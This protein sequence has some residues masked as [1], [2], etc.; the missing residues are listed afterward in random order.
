MPSFLFHF[1]AS[2]SPFVLSP[3]LFLSHSHHSPFLL[4]N[5]TLAL[6]ASLAFLSF[7][8][9]VPFLD[10][11]PRTAYHSRFWYIRTSFHSRNSRSGSISIT[12]IKMITPLPPSPPHQRR[13][14]SLREQEPRQTSSSGH[15]EGEG[16]GS[17]W[18]SLAGYCLQRVIGNICV[19]KRPS[20]ARESPPGNFPSLLSDL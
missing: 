13:L 7:F 15:K 14:N 9:F 18:Q 19:M 4:L 6:F 11:S 17:W 1:S 8:Q 10:S 5:R 3:S 2:Y 20:S 12:T 16:R